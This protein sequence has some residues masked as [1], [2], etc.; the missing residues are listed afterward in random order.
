MEW[1]CSEDSDNPGDW[2]VEVPEKGYVTVFSGP[3]AQRRAEEYG[4][5][6]N[7]QARWQERSLY[8]EGRNLRSV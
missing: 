1:I 8:F 4:A 5:F 7:A 2:R 3:E 6:E